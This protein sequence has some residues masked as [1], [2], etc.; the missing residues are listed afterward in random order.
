MIFFVIGDTRQDNKKTLKASTY[1][2]LAITETTIQKPS[3]IS[4][5]DFRE[6]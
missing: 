1:V 3:Y 5:K 4:Q 6:F 2:T